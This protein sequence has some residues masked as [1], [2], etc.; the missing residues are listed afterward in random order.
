MPGNR[1]DFLLLDQLALSEAQIAQ[2]SD[3]F[4][5]QHL[6]AAIQ[7]DDFDVLSNQVLNLLLILENLTGGDWESDRKSDRKS[8]RGKTND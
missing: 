7:S 8:D 4:L 1:V 6:V 2:F 3:H 5:L